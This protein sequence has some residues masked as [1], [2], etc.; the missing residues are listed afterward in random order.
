M[1]SSLTRKQRDFSNRSL[2]GCPERALIYGDT[3]KISVTN[4]SDPKCYLTDARP[5]DFIAWSAGSPSACGNRPS[6]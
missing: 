4:Q 2:R 1:A 3:P 5:S 6:R